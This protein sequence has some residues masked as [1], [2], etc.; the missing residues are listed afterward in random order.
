MKKLLFGLLL[1]AQPALAACPRYQSADVNTQQ[2]IQG[3]CHDLQYPSIS[4]GSASTMTITQLNVSTIT[5]SGTPAAANDA[6]KFSQIKYFQIVMSSS[7][8]ST[9]TTSTSFVDTSLKRNITP[10]S[11]NSKILILASSEIGGLIAGKSAFITITRNGTD[12]SAGSGFTSDILVNASGAFRQPWAAAYLDSPATTSA[13][14]YV[15]Q[16][17]NGVGGGINLNDDGGVATMYLV[18]VQ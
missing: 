11:V 9:T 16:I 15:V 4:I 17:K 8:S 3:I 5:I 6:A 2:E 10:S 12:L 13:T 1:I 18:E 14:S 7:T